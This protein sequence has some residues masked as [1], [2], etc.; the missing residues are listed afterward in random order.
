MADEEWLE[1]VRALG[2][3]GFLQQFIAD[4]SGAS[5]VPGSSA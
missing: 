1:L 2:Q 3:D 4:F 5:S